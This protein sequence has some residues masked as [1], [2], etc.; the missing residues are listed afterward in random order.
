MTRARNGQTRPGDLP[1][2]GTYPTS[3]AWLTYATAEGNRVRIFNPT[4]QPPK[5]HVE[6]KGVTYSMVAIGQQ[7]EGLTLQPGDVY[8][9]PI[10]AIERNEVAEIALQSRRKN[11]LRSGYRVPN[12]AKMRAALR[13]EY[14]GALIVDQVPRPKVTK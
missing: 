11:A 3:Y 7:V 5:E 12:M 8:F 10:T 1:I 4:N 2:L 13:R 14:H 6:I 9:R